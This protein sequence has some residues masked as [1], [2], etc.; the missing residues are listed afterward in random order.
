MLSK[1]LINNAIKL[2]TTA[3]VIGSVSYADTVTSVADDGSPGTLRRVINEASP[4]ATVD[5]HKSLNKQ[6]IVLTNPAVLRLD[7]NLTITAATLPDGITIDASGRQ[8][9]VLI[10]D[11][12]VSA[13]LNKL[14][15]TGGTEGGILAQGNLTVNDCQIVHN[16]GSGIRSDNNTLS[17]NN[18]VISENVSRNVGG[19]AAGISKRGGSLI[20]RNSTLS[21]NVN[22]FPGPYSAS[23]IACYSDLIL[24]GCSFTNN[25]ANRH[26][27]V[28]FSLNAEVTDCS[29]S[30]NR[31]SYALESLQIW[32]DGPH[33][34]TI[35]HSV[36]TD[37]ESGGLERYMGDYRPF[38]C[39]LEDCMFYRNQSTAIYNHN[40]PM[41][42]RRC[43]IA[44]NTTPPDRTDLIGGIDS[45]GPTII[46]DTT[47]SDNSGYRA[48]GIRLDATSDQGT[49][50]QLIRTTVDNNRAIEGPGG[51]LVN[52]YHPI[53][54]T[55]NNCTFSGNSSK[56]NDGGGIVWAAGL[57]SMGRFVATTVTGNSA[58]RG[59]GIFVAP[60]SRLEMVNNL[61]AQNFSSA[62]LSHD[63]DGSPVSEGGNLIERLDGSSGWGPRD[64]TGTIEQPLDP[65][66]S[67]LDDHGGWTL[68]HAL[69][70]GSP[71]IDAAIPGLNT[72]D[73]RGVA[74][75]N[76]PD[77]GSYEFSGTGPGRGAWQGH[78]VKY[79]YR[80]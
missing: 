8:R 40:G 71:A 49:N 74:R 26:P 44:S 25:V 21:N 10:T 35:R 24:S 18:S 61:V 23:A 73:Q 77:I 3:F 59:G 27:V 12:G 54:V 65:V 62:D 79:R 58:R 2:A 67:P 76:A 69:L 37:N 11:S 45:R 34:T 53:S 46:E 17:I 70:K 57:N 13:S 72:E 22:E 48:G 1:R 55:T 63:V 42:I 19:S 60:G 51:M 56:N 4:G 32:D 9:P 14:T 50:V 7:K 41:Q 52:S 6:R 30:N 38:P 33:T 47:V 31:G 15:V 43:W 80:K 39:V 68:T 16:V 28:S 36:F 75:D 20:I 5:F 29:F 64:L 78:V 66:I